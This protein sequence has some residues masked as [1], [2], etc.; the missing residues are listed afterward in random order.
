MRCRTMILTLVAGL[1]LAHGFGLW[2]AAATAAEAKG[3][4]VATVTPTVKPAAAENAWRYVY[5]NGQW[6]YW[7][8]ENRWVYWQNRRWNNY[9]PAAVA[10]NRATAPAP[11]SGLMLADPAANRDEVRPFYGHA[12]SSIYYGPS[13][14]EEIG[15]FYGNALPRDVFGP[16][17]VPRYRNRP[18]YGHAGSSYMY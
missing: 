9:A 6:W 13:G 3:P 18:N 10:E 1:T 2:T 5:F 15:P 12:E 14:Q 17:V 11:Q 4:A 7:L 16:R 8:P